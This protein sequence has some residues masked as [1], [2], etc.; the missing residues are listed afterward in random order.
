MHANIVLVHPEP[1]SFNGQLV[2]NPKE[3]LQNSGWN[4]SISALYRMKFDPCERPDFYPDP[5]DS[6]RY[7]GGEIS[8]GTCDTSPTNRY[9]TLFINHWDIVFISQVGEIPSSKW[10]SE[11][12]Y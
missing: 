9:P 12:V 1:R 8:S 10:L 4:V 11:I 7:W 3:S 2:T 5:R 6:T